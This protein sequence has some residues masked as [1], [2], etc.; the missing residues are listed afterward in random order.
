M[1]LRYVCKPTLIDF[2]MSMYEIVEVEFLGHIFLLI[3]R[4]EIL[5]DECISI[6]LKID[7]NVGRF[8]L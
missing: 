8:G 6:H 5:V 7:S 4:K 3:G 1:A 2:F